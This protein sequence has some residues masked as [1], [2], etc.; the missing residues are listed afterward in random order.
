MQASPLQGRKAPSAPVAGIRHVIF[1]LDG[2]LFDTAPDIATALRLAIGD[3]SCDAVVEKAVRQGL[4][5]DE[6]IRAALGQDTP[7][8]VRQ[9]ITTDFRRYYDAS[10]FAGT[11]AY[12]GIPELLKRLKASGRDLHIATNKRERP[13]LRILEHKGMRAPF[14]QIV[15]VDSDGGKLTK[16]QMLAR[17]L[18]ATHSTAP[19]CVIIGDGVNDVV[20]GRELGLYAVG[21][22]YGY[23]ERQAI[24]AS[25]PRWLCEHVDELLVDVETNWLAGCRSET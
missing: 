20:A 2:T 24:V 19:E 10:D 13:T 11:S 17:I 23:G 5:L 15:C 16:R 9:R 22:L 25:G 3:S 12:P 7:K 18:D 6:M 21:V 4:P 1:D 14:S 8:D